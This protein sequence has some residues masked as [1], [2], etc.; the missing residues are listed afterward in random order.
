[1][2]GFLDNGLQLLPAKFAG[3]ETSAEAATDARVDEESLAPLW[4]QRFRGESAVD[5]S[6][7]RWDHWWKLSPSI[8][9]GAAD[10]DALDARD[11]ETVGDAPRA[12]SAVA[13]RF[14]NGDP[15]LVTGR[16]GEGTVILLAGPLDTD[17]S[18]LPSKNDFVPFLH[19]MVFQLAA[20]TRNR[21]VPA[22]APLV[23]PLS[24]PG[25]AGSIRF[26]DPTGEEH[27]AKLAGTPERPLAR[28]DQTELPGVYRA[29]SQTN[30]T[31]PAEFFVV[32]FDRRESDLT[33]L[34]ADQQELLAGEDRLLFIET[35]DDLV[36]ATSVESPPRE[37]WKFL[38]LAVLLLLVAEVA[39]TRRLVQGGHEAVDVDEAV[40]LPGLP[41]SD[42]RESARLP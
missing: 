26:V 30:P 21:N 39:M 24:G 22:G 11:D 6:A 9:A 42:Q 32:T 29:R 27:A 17:W 25:E 7:A 15:F 1:N 18:T 5:F 20:G 41:S 19:E 38:L 13:A 4:L 14:T 37:I 16:V 35:V 23:L 34:A 2:D 12:E 8:A 40:G 3:L 31:G 33:P 36:A 28:L 10:P